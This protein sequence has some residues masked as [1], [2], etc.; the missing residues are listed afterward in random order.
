MRISRLIFPGFML[1]L[2]LLA[3][4]AHPE[5][6][7]PP[8]PPPPYGYERS[9]VE[10][11]THNGYQDGFNDGHRDVYAGFRFRPHYDRRF[12]ATPGYMGGPMPFHAYRNLYREGYE[13][14][15]RNGY[16]RA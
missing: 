1:G 8:P 13:R 16:A 14:G 12:H 9:F 2:V 6:A 5:Y 10:A 11:A 7:G 3:G 15:Y 4:C